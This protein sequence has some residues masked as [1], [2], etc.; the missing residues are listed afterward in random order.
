MRIPQ[1]TS[2]SRYDRTFVCL[3]AELFLNKRTNSSGLHAWLYDCHDDESAAIF[4]SVRS[5]DVM[6]G[7]VQWWTHMKILEGWPVSVH[8]ACPFS[9]SLHKECTKQAHPEVPVVE[10]MKDLWKVTSCIRS[11]SARRN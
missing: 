6:A 3:T 2:T 5:I 11:A 10:N 1:R 7:I 4:L 8:G 9:L